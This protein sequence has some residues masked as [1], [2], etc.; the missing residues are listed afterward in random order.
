MATLVHRETRPF[1]DLFDWL[2]T[3][4][5]S[6]R[7]V[8]AQAM[9]VEDYVNDGHYVIRAELPGID[10]E[11]EVEVTVA[12]GILT[13]KANRQE[14]KV[15]KHH[16]EFRYGVFSRQV[17]LPAEADADH[18]RASYDQGILEVVVDLKDKEAIDAVTHIP[19]RP[20]KHIKPT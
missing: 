15:D 8:A 2:E 9:R 11:N 17:T 18:V 19:V 10:P 13:I 1:A 6:I 12:H 7:P 4:L 16:S 3:P 14:Q 5:M 20:S